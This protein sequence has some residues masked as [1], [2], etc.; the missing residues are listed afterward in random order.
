MEAYNTV[1]VWV[2]LSSPGR[3]WCFLG[4]IGTDF[5]KVSRKTA[6]GCLFQ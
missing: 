1:K 3:E 6:A 2:V 4:F 5:E